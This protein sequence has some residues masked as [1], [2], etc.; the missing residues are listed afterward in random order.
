MSEMDRS[1]PSS[2]HSTETTSYPTGCLS[3]NDASTN[4][5]ESDQHDVISE[6]VARPEIRRMTPSDD[7]ESEIDD[8]HRWYTTRASD[9]EENRSIEVAQ[10]SAS[11]MQEINPTSV[12]N[13]SGTSNDSGST[14]DP[15]IEILSV[16]QRDSTVETGNGEIEA[17]SDIQTKLGENESNDAIFSPKLPQSHVLMNL[18]SGRGTG[19]IQARDSPKSENSAQ[20]HLHDSI[21]SGKRGYEICYVVEVEVVVDLEVVGPVARSEQLLDLLTCCLAVV[22]TCYLVDIP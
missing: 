22:V 16:Q 1:N 8:L 3:E 12:A 21:V 5:W 20:Q 4:Q 14:F 2:I 19:P 15:A 9:I 7:V 6:P 17:K 18:S 10:S 13:H 11:S